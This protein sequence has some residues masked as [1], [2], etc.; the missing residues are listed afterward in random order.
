MAI[1]KRR[2][3]EAKSQKPMV[4]IVCCIGVFIFQFLSGCATSVPGFAYTPGVSGQL[5]DKNGKRLPGAYILYDYH[6]YTPGTLGGSSP[7]YIKNPTFTVTD[8]NGQFAI[9]SLSFK[10][11]LGLGRPKFNILAGYS[12]I[13]HSAFF[14][15]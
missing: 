4:V 9:P 15:N 5:V 11:P 1:G 12:P 6:G 14:V 7:D 13:T 2:K 3:L 10:K 8:T